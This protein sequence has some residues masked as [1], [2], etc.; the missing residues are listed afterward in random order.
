MGNLGL[1]SY[2]VAALAAI[3]LYREH[4][5][6]GGYYPQ[7]GMQSFSD[8]LLE[9]FREYGGKVLL[10]TKVNKLRVRNNKIKNVLIDKTALIRLERI[11]RI[12]KTR[13]NKKE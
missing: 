8:A 7:G 4:I 11:K 9:R 10:S 3:F 13:K 5:F 1:P 6:D 12:Y 2:R